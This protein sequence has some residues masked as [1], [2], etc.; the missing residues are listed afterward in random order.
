MMFNDKSDIYVNW[1]T[2]MKYM[3]TKHQRKKAVGLSMGVMFD[4]KSL[5]YARVLDNRAVLSVTKDKDKEQRKRRQK[6]MLKNGLKQAT[7]KIKKYPYKNINIL[8]LTV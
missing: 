8:D 7:K 6:G 5:E 2:F 3:I 4:I 1:R